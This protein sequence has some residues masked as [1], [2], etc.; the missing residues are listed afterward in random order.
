MHLQMDGSAELG[1]L[2]SAGLQPQDPGFTV[3]GPQDDGLYFPGFQG[4]AFFPF[5]TTVH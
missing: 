5:N 2:P 3:V 1:S 4:C